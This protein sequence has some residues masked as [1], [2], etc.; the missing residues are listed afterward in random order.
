M[1]CGG[2]ISL[3]RHLNNARVNFIDSEAELIRED[4]DWSEQPFIVLL[5]AAGRLRLVLGLTSVQVYGF[6][7]LLVIREQQRAYGGGISN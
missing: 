2:T 4:H 1:S 5:F 6:R 3:K 7:R